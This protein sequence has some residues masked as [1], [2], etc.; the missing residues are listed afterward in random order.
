MA[1]AEANELI[2]DLAEGVPVAGGGV[3]GGERVL[4]VA[5]E[6]GAVDFLA[7]HAHGEIGFGHPRGVA[8]DHAH[9][10]LR[11]IVL[12][13]RGELAHDAEVVEAQTAVRHHEHVARMRIA[14]EE[15][16]LEDLHEEKAQEFARQDGAAGGGIDQTGRSALAGAALHGEHAR[17]G[18]VPEDLRHDHRRLLREVRAEAVGV[19]SFAAEVEFRQQRRREF[20][21]QFERG[22][23]AAFGDVPLEL[24]REEVHDR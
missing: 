3:E 8:R 16:V 7:R 4:Q 6:G 22:E 23:F 17:R 24:P 12:F 14:V 9:Q 13:R 19:A 11:E 10:E 20:V 15:P 5:A 18:Q 1:L 2:E 21:D